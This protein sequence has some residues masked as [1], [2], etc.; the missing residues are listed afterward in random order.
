MIA[1]LFAVIV[2]LAGAMVGALLLALVLLLMGM[3]K[4]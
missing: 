1:E 3:S 4:G 2:F